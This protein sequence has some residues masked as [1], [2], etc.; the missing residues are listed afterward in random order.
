[1]FVGNSIAHSDAT[2][3]CRPHRHQAHPMFVHPAH[4]VGIEAHESGVDY[5]NLSLTG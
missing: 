1:M 3:I 2:Q 4:S 5:G